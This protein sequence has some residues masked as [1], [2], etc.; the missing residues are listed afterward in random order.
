MTDIIIKGGHVVTMDSQI[1]DLPT[2]DVHVRGERIIA[3][4][5][6]LE[7]SGAEIIDASNCIVT[8]GFID[9]H[10]HA[11]QSLLRGAAADWSL[12][13]YMVEARAMYCGCFDSETA[14]VAN[15]IGGLESIDAGIT[16]IVDHS[17]L[18]KS[19]EVSDALARGLLDSGV[20]GFFCYALQ[21]VP[22]FLNGE[23]IDEKSLGEML[24]R[25]ADD[26]HYENAERVRE[27]FFKKS[28]GRL[29]FGVAMFEGT[30]YVPH[31][32]SQLLFERA[33]KLQPNLITSH[34]NAISKPGFY[35]SSLS[36]LQKAGAFTLPTLLSHNNQ[37]SEDDLKLM[38][39]S[40][41]GLCTCPDT[42]CG[43]GLGSLLARKFMEMGGA[44][45]LGVDITCY[46]EADMLRQ[47]SLMLQTERKAHAEANGCLPMRVG[48]GA[49]A[50]LEL[51]TIAGARSIGLEHEIGSLT[52]GKRADV[53]VIEP[54]S[55]LSAPITDPVAT[56]LFYTN[57]SDIKTVM[58]HGQLLKRDGQLQGVDLAALRLRSSKA[59]ERVRRRYQELP[60]EKFQMVW[61]SMF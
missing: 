50:A 59:L 22:D 49:R 13:Q 6:H 35:L 47:A 4:G 7:V 28:D 30:A 48:W 57:K 1:G 53:L 55:I 9:G 25:P 21:N 26:W 20:G 51:I 16:T 60:H 17:H 46:V 44:A 37:L 39:T 29:R 14:Y 42:E 43:M 18:Q 15:Y 8:P 19:P 61:A 32:F 10:R 33:Q 38:A 5:E 34:W 23:E 52:P 45:S 58:V 11:W 2:G 54:K 41:I 27:S 40:N 36:D 12:P 31:E 56:L 3:V 24:T